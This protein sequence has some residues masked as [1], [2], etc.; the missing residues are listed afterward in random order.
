MKYS[1]VLPCYNESD[2]ITIL[3]ERFCKFI[4]DWD[5]ELLLVDNGSTDNTAEVLEQIQTKPENS[6][7][8]MVT[9]KKN[10]GYGHGIHTGLRT[11]RGEIL[12]YSHADVQTPPEDI[13]RAF[14]L[15]D[16]GSVDIQR[17]IIKGLRPG[18]DKSNLF[19]RWLR[20]ITKLLTGV[21]VEDINGQP[22]VFHRGL[23]EAMKKPVTDFSYDTYLLYSASRAGLNIKAIEVKF[24]QR[25]H[26]RS[27]WAGTF[28][29][30]YKTIAMYIV[31]IFLMSWR[32]RLWSCSKNIH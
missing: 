15:I 10:I 29:K 28:L 8:R 16:N 2:N 31:N 21:R 20:I 23:L 1:I 13:F 19:T 14:E 5:F 25:L 9:I 7:V 17:A 26:G 24:E 11:A 32:D 3:V 27:K 22:K 18:R 4:K 30:K 6:F 12:A